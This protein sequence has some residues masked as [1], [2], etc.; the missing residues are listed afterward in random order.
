MDKLGMPELPERSFAAVSE[1]MQHSLYGYL[2]TPAVVLG[3]L[4]IAAK[5]NVRDDDAADEK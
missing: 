5:R 3:G 2:I 4:I 1:T